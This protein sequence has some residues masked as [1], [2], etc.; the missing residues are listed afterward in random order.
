M[1]GLDKLSALDEFFLLDNEKNRANVLT[2]VKMDKVPDYEELKN[3]LT[4][5]AIAKPRLRHKLRKMFGEYFFEELSPQEL[6]KAIDKHFVRDDSI[7]NDDDIAAFLAKE[8]SI[9]DPLDT[10]QYSFIFVPE[11]SSN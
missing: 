6:K 3:R 1:M 7:K 2:V 11:F 4:K 5:L 10:L 8:Q 9:R